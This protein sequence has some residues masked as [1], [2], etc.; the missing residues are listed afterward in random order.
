MRN[1]GLPLTTESRK[2]FTEVVPTTRLAYDSLVDFVPGVERDWLPTVVDLAPDD[3][4][5]RVVVT[6]PPMHDD[7]W[8]AR[9]TAGRE[10]E[11]DNLTKVIA[12]R[13]A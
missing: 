9:L 10:N 11:M 8:T 6:F 12:A 1:A 13:T 3:G 2:T 5:T 7:V 4:G